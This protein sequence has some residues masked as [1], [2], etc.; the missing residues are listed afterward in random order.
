MPR[1]VLLGNTVTGILVPRSGQRPPQAAAVLAID[2]HGLAGTPEAEP[3]VSLT[4]DRDVAGRTATAPQ[5][6]VTTLGNPQRVL[7]A[8][9]EIADGEEEN[10]LGS[11]DRVP[12]PA[13]APGPRPSTRI[14]WH[15]VPESVAWSL[16]WLVPWCHPH[17]PDP[18]PFPPEESLPHWFTPV[19]GPRP[20]PA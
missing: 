1:D 9:Q 11:L 2:A 12:P 16:C 10:L 15:A 19:P 7:T 13:L 18:Q 20:W 14:T 4:L 6:T 17:E 5:C 3:A 8:W